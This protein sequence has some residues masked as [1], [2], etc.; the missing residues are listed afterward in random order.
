MTNE[1][2]SQTQ[3]QAQSQ[4]Q[5]QSQESTNAVNTSDEKAYWGMTLKD[6][7]TLMHFSQLLGIIVPY[8]GLVLPLVMWLDG[9]QKHELIDIHGK[10]IVNWM[11]SLM[12]YTVASIFLMLIFVGFI[13]FFAAVILAIVF[14]II[15][16]LKASK[17]EVWEYPLTIKFI[18]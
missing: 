9:K 6:Y 11:I 1:N 18:K 2:Q 17:G 8:A 12:I 10:N 7:I 4:Q 14:P 15:G 5:G 3:N 13:T 16:G